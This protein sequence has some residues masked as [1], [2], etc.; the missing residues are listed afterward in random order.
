MLH[1]VPL[2]LLLS[3]APA[4]GASPPSDPCPVRA[5]E[6]CVLVLRGPR[7]PSA[8]S[9][10]TTPAWASRL[11]LSQPG[12][13]SDSNRD[14]FFET[15][16]EIRLDPIKDCGCARF[17]VLYEDPVRAWTVHLGN[18]PTNN[19]HGGDEGTTPNAAE[20]QVLDGR[21]S[22][23]TASRAAEHR[24]DKLLDETLPALGGRTMEFEVCNQ[25]LGVEILPTA[26]DPEPR[27]WK[28]ETLNSKLLFF[29]GPEQVAPGR[30]AATSIYAAFNRV[31]HALAG[32]ASHGRVGSG[33][34][35]VEISLIP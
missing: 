3:L 4:A 29:L 16:L 7:A 9:A 1:A 15:V 26:R 23:F 19:G 5:G 27:R 17:K 8:S 20:L 13:W 25:A 24:V 11:T 18:S 2:A 34:R 28:L 32:P 12:K 14:G 21:L 33:V 31:I 10:C 30:D 22:V 35:R 6:P